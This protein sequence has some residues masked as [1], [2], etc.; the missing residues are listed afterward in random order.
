[1]MNRYFSILVAVFTMIGGSQFASASLKPG[2]VSVNGKIKEIDRR[3]QQVV[4]VVNKTGKEV[5]VPFEKKK[6]TIHY[7]EKKI[8]RTRYLSKGDD[9]HIQF[10]IVYQPLSEFTKG[11]DS[12]EGY[13]VRYIGGFDKEYLDSKKGEKSER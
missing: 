13:V 9:M 2:E 4:M 6:V 10:M 3:K 12:F 7:N 5:T 11:N 1:M 8:S